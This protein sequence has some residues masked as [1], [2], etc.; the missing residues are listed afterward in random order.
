M[1][2]PNSPLPP[3]LVKE[4]DAALARLE[5]ADAAAAGPHW[6][7]MHKLLLKAKVDPHALMRVVGARDVG[8]LR[9]VVARA[10]GEAVEDDAGAGVGPAGAGAGGDAGAGAAAGA[11]AGTAPQ[12]FDVALLQEALRHFRKR[13]KLSQLDADSRLGH[14]PMSGTGQYRIQSMVP[15]RDYP[16]AVWEALVRAGKLRREGDGFY[17]IIEQ[18]G[19]AHW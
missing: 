19:G 4:I 15:P 8:E 18:P 5:A 2:A 3:Q 13:L 6:G 11:G 7:A 14:G 10:K 16:H 9:R 17:S 12:E 1:T